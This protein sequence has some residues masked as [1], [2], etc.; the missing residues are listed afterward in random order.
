MSCFSVLREPELGGREWGREGGSEGGSGEKEEGREGVK[1]GRDS[2]REG[3]REGEKGGER[4]AE[5]ERGKRRR[6]RERKRGGGSN[7]R[8]WDQET[9]C[10]QPGIDLHL[11]GPQK[12]LRG[13][14][15]S[16]ARAHT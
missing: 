10:R 4:A 1:R 13:G 11:C 9:G 15:G 6:E 8:D 2:G 7:R 12:E 5:R 16:P 3:L 14:V